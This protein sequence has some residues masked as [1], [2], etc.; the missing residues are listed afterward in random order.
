[1]RDFWYQLEVS[2]NGH[3]VVLLRRLN[4]HLAELTK[5]IEDSVCEVLAI[6]VQPI[7]ISLTPPSAQ[8]FHDTLAQLF[9][10]GTVLCAPPLL[11]TRDNWV[12]WNTISCIRRAQG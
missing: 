4:A 6:E 3:Q 9:A 8:D 10:A 1:M 5:E 7:A 2:T 12:L 11:R